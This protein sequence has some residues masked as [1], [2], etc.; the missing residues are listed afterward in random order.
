M[1]SACKLFTTALLFALVMSGCARTPSQASDDMDEVLQDMQLSTDRVVDSIRDHRITGWRYV[2]R[3]HLIITAQ[4]REHYLLSFN[5][6]C[7]GLSG[8]FS[9]GFTS[10]AGGLTR[11]DNIV[12]RGPGSMIDTCPIKEIIRL[13]DS[14]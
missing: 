14:E 6:P 9:I 3:Y 5:T 13:K 2:D 10:T 12:V 8:A 7:L 1:N 4:R 11:F